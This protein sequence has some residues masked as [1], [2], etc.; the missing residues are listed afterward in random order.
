MNL[1]FC[2][3]AY[4]EKFQ[5]GHNVTASDSR[6]VY[7]KNSYVALFSAKSF[8]PTSEVALITNLKLDR[9]WTVRFQKAGIKIFYCQYDDF[10]FDEKYGWSLAYF[11]LCA[12]KYSLTL[13][14]DNYL[15]L[16]TDTYTQ[17]P[18]DDIFKECEHN[19]LLNDISRGLYNGDYMTF[20]KEAQCFLQ[21]D[22]YLTR[23]GG[24]FIAGNKEKLQVFIDK[25]YNTYQK[26]KVEKFVTINGDEFITSC[27][28]HEMR[29]EVKNAIAYVFRYWTAWRWH[30]VCS[31]YKH[32]PVCVL[33]CP[34]EKDHG[35]LKLY[36]Y[37]NK[38]NRLPK[39]G[40]VYRKLHL[41]GASYTRRKFVMWLGAF[42]K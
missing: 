10:L 28:A 4:K 37:I 33:H 29:C 14:Y 7:L 23:W 24:E 38:K 8:N 21:T 42:F 13:N 6:E 20:V 2:A 3:Y 11:K 32:N 16:D 30:F 41:D 19:I 18:F 36:K 25:S 35:F 1:I 17:R 39:I 5:A 27:V 15:L 22:E 12:L 26:M 31:N 34:R 9:A 40:W